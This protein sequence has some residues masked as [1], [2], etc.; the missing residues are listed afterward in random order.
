MCRTSSV[1]RHFQ[2]KHQYKFKTSEEISEAIKKSISSFKKQTGIL[3]QAVGSKNKATECS[4]KIAQCVAL[5]GKPFT[6]GEYIKETFLKSA[7]ILFGDSLNKEIIVS[8]ITAIPVFSRS[9]ARRITDSA[10]NVTTKQII[11]LKQA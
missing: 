11:G 10:E 4:Y 9:V 7:E 8:R 2:T 5:K 6:D 1:Q 3:S